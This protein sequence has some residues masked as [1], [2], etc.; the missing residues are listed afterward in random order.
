MGRNRI[1]LRFLSQSSQ[2]GDSF[3]GS[4]AELYQSTGFPVLLDLNV[5]FRPNA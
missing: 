4:I 1:Y 2:G 3:F 5:K